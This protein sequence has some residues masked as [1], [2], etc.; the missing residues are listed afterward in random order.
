M[1]EIKF[2]EEGFE[3]FYKCTQGIPLYINSFYNIMDSNQVYTSEIVKKNILYKYEPNFNNAYKSWSS[4]NKN[5][6]N[7][8]QILVDEKSL[9]WSELLEK[10]NFSRSTFSKY[11]KNLKYKGIVNYISKKYF[12]EDEMLRNWLQYER[13]NGF[14]S[15]LNHLKTNAGRIYQIINHN[16]KDSISLNSSFVISLMKVSSLLMVFSAKSILFLTIK[17]MFS[18]RVPLVMNL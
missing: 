4:L 7:I 8:V 9:T 14:L 11:L 6:K 12:L 10:T 3:R 17:S 1:S 2:T 5:E 18:S 16:L 15:N 13:N